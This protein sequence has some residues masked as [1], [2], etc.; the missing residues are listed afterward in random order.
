V[1]NCPYENCIHRISP[2]S[3]QIS[4]MLELANYY[5]I[6]KSNHEPIA[7]SK[8]TEEYGARGTEESSPSFHADFDVKGI[9]TPH[10]SNFAS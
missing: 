5:L 1:S 6:E 7:C 10:S 4:R 2:R 9:I 3:H 8:R